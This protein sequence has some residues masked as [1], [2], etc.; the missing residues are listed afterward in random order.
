[1]RCE[2]LTSVRI[3]IVIWVMA[4]CSLTGNY[5]RFG[6][7]RTHEDGRNI[8]LQTLDNHP[9]EYICDTK[10][11]ALNKNINAYQTLHHGCKSIPLE[12]NTLFRDSSV[13][14]ITGYGLDDLSSIPGMVGI[15]FTTSR[16]ALGS[17]QTPIQWIPRAI[18]PG[19]KRLRRD[20]DNSPPL[21]QM[22]SWHSA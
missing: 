7:I 11:H 3:Q 5:Q 12:Y 2:V 19:L 1:M 6:R 15:F 13:D 10:A 18:S 16:P 17:T 9:E 20:A 4:Q 22:S 21:P 14:I 8:F